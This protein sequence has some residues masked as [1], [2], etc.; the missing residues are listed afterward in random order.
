METL[1]KWVGLDDDSIENC[2]INWHTNGVVVKSE[3]VGRNLHMRYE[4][5]TDT[6]WITTYCELSGYNAEFDFHFAFKRDNNGSWIGNGQHDSRFDHCDFVDIS[7]TPFTNSLPINNLN[8]S[9]KE[10]REI[11]V[12]YFDFSER[13]IRPVRQCYT[14]L[15]KYLYHYENVPNDFEADIQVDDKGLIVDYPG[16]F[17]R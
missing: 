10:A 7:L 1:I 8:L 12:V 13:L 3:I 16:L 5:R 11:R 15:S 14:K 9:E 4:I 6:H 2:L 17:T